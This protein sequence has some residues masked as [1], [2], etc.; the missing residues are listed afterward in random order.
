MPYKKPSKRARKY[1]PRRKRVYRKRKTYSDTVLIPRAKV[2]GFPKSIFT[3]LKYVYNG[4]LN[5]GVGGTCSV[6]VFR[7]N[8][9]YDP[10][11]SGVGNQPRGFD[12]WHNVYHHHFV[13]RSYIKV[14]FHNGDATYEQNVGVN[15]R[16]TVSTETDPVNY[17]EAD[18]AYRML[19]RVGSSHNDITLR[20]SFDTRRN[21]RLDYTNANNRGSSSAV[22]AEEMF[23]HVW[24]AN[25]WGS[26]SSNAYI[27]V[28]IYYQVLFSELK[29]ITQS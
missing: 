21:L 28:T 14:Q 13:K 20:R 1:V 19:G 9:P 29:A 15:L 5:P 16:P 24:S 27:E 26:D 8:G 11:A 22:P 17:Q 18:G 7:A 6:V 3:T 25:K 12:E 23:F 10:D 4:T 2:G